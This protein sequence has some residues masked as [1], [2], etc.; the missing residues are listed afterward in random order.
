MFMNITSI[1]ADEN[2]VDLSC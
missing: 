2:N 1:N